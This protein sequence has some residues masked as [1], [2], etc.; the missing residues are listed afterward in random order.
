MN[1]N[2]P[3]ADL[4]RRYGFS[5]EQLAGFASVFRSD[6]LQG[7][8]YLVSGGGS[9]MG[10]A[11]CF[12]LAGLG[13]QVMISGRH[14][15]KLSA[16]AQDV[17]RLT[18]REV[19]CRPTNIREPDEV[20]GLLD[21]AFASF[22]TLDGVINSAGGQFAQNAIDFSRKGW[23]AV[24]DTNLNGT[25]WMMQ[26]AARRWK[27][28]GS[29]GSIVNVVASFVRGIPQQAHTAAARAAVTYLSKSVAV[30]WAPLGIRVNCIAPGT[31]E[32][33]GLN[34]YGPAFADRLGKSNPMRT[35]GDAMDIAQAIVYLLADSAKFVTGELLQ[36]DGGGQLWGNSFP[37][38]VPEH[39]RNAD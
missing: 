23:N 28:N 8:S 37:L 22:G 2:Q 33:E 31:I 11:T 5:S 9:G 19:L 29:P 25:W 18:G 27:A 14:E 30:E 35:V 34:N 39:L 4:Q 7:R 16:V 17:G 10:R 15:G 21:S 3:S 26:A 36:V 38:G 13:A 12:L 32:T 20:E 24:I 1:S 6:L